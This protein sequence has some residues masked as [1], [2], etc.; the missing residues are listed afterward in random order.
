MITCLI[1]DD[2][3]PAIDIL[4][5]HVRQTP[6][7]NLVHSTT[8]PMEALEWVNNKKI[9]IIFLDIQMPDIS[10]IDF[11]KTMKASSKVIFTTAYSEFA[12]DGFDLEVVDYLLKPIS[13]PRFLRA[14]QRA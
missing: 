5:H 11:V 6:F 14:V 12:T 1:L 9:D 3:Q 2:E 10:G 4:E 8:S 7:L 13:L